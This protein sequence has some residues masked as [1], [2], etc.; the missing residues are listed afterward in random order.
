MVPGRSW[1]EERTFVRRTPSVALLQVRRTGAR[2]GGLPEPSIPRCPRPTFEP[3]RAVGDW[4]GEWSR[5][6]GVPGVAPG[7]ATSGA[8]PGLPTH[9]GRAQTGRDRA[10]PRYL[11]AG[12][13]GGTSTR[14]GSGD[15]RAGTTGEG[16]PLD[17][18]AA[19]AGVALC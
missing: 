9:P 13:R 14:G 3:P 7:L 10:S 5:G 17:R 15:N 1:E 6:C 11:G 12:V 16:S 18:G 4:A 2:T 19:G 8:W